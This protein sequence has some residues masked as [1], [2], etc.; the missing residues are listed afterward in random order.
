MTM[1]ADRSA[2]MTTHDFELLASAAPDA[3]TLEFVDGE[4]RV[5]PVPDGDHGEII[6]WL[7]ERCM[8]QRPDFRLYPEQG[9]VVERYGKGRARPDGT[10]APKG[11][12]AGRGE[13]AD[14]D[15]VLMT[16]EVTSSRADNDRSAKANGYAAAGIPVYLL[17]DRDS[18]ELV[19]HSHPEQGCY[20][21]VHRT[22]G[23]GEELL[24]PEPV[25]VRLDTEA[26]KAFM[27]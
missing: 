8:S 3:V 1:T 24:L 16:V 6:M 21:D 7:L 13:W 12:F 4:L 17:V 22:T 11:Y 25:G 23:L 18:H 5:K 20:R 10:L 2:Q 14:P 9:L 15:R 27:D 26:L 19:V